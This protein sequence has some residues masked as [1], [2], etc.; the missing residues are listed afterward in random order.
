MVQVQ[1]DLARKHIRL[2][3]AGG[4]R[5][6]VLPKQWLAARG[7]EDEADLILTS[8]GILVV[9]RPRQARSIEDEPEFA[10]FLAFLAK[11]SL[12]HPTRLGDVGDLMNGDEEIFA[13]VEPA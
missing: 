1:E 8:E 5:T 9:G 11:E 12:R 13:G 10:H 2:G 3:R 4:S 7:I 6:A